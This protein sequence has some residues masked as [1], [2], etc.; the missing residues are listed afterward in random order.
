[1]FECEGIDFGRRHRVSH[2]RQAALAADPRDAPRAVSGGLVGVRRRGLLALDCRSQEASSDA[3]YWVALA[4]R[5][6]SELSVEAV[7]EPEGVVGFWC[8]RRCGHW[9]VPFLETGAGKC[10]RPRAFGSPPE[11]RSVRLRGRDLTTRRGRCYR[12]ACYLDSIALILRQCQAAKRKIPLY[13][14]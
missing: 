6:S 7:R 14:S 1:M 3:R 11:V 10:R 4:L 5:D 2:W 9:S 12:G 13:A 8:G